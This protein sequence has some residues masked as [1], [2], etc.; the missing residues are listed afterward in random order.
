MKTE[1][2]VAVVIRITVF[3]FTINTILDLLLGS[4]DIKTKGFFN[5][6]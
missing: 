2:V 4:S 5:Y 6:T 1:I 3:F